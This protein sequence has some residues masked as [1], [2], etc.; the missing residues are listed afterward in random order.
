[1]EKKREIISK[2]KRYVGIVINDKVDKTIKVRVERMATHPLYKKKIKRSKNLLVH[3]ETNS[4]HIGDKVE[5]IESRPI[6]KM[7]KWR[8]LRIIEKAK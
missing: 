6:S 2:K 7:K 1:M 4:A 5:V 3:D 8:L